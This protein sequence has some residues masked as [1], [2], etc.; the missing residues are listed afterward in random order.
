MLS[1]IQSLFVFGFALVVLRTA[2]YFGQY[3]ECNNNAVLV[4]FR[5]FKVF[6]NGRI[7][8]WIICG[9]FMSLYMLMIYRDYL[10]PLFDIIKNHMAGCKTHGGY[11]GPALSTKR[12]QNLGDTIPQHNLDGPPDPFLGHVRSVFRL[13]RT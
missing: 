3:P 4:L 11:E 9:A 7:A 13:K 2:P 5:P 10:H 6:N 12:A 8:G 1:V